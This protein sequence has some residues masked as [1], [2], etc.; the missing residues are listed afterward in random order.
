MALNLCRLLLQNVLIVIPAKAGIQRSNL[1]GWIM[2]PGLRRD[3]RAFKLA[4]FLGLS[5]CHWGQGGI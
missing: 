2:D 4:V 1:H 3:D 5:K